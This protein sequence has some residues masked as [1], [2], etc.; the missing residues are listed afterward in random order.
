MTANHF[1]QKE[2]EVPFGPEI[3]VI[4]DNDRSRL[5]GAFLK[6]IGMT[7]RV[8]TS[9]KDA[10]EALGNA[11]AETIV[12]L[13][14]MFPNSPEEGLDFLRTFKLTHAQVP[15]IVFTNASVD[16]DYVRGLG[17][18]AVVSKTGDPI[19]LRNVIKLISG[20][21]VLVA[22]VLCEI[23]GISSRTVRIRVEGEQG[24]VAE[25]D[26]ERE[27]CPPAMEVGGAFYLETYEFMRDGKKQY[28]VASKASDPREELAALDGWFE[29]L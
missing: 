23:V 12:V 3:F 15:V 25:R 5:T 4:D 17:A 1:I 18:A 14:L 16:E 27:F 9:L 7:K 8:V 13:D 21:E 6:E 26:F 22:S 24:W 20:R 11:T 2:I 29:G 19:R 28:R 10:S